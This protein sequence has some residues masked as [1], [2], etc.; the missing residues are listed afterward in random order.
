MKQHKFILAS[1]YSYKVPMR[2]TVTVILTTQTNPL[3]VECLRY[4]CAV[5]NVVESKQFLAAV[6]TICM[7]TIISFI[8]HS[9]L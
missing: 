8:K 4:K 9:Y 5:E 3:Y 7:R 6:F 2:E 1:C